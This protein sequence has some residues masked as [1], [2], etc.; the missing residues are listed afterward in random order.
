MSFKRNRKPLSKR[1]RTLVQ[2]ANW[3]VFA[4]CATSAAS[5][6]AVCA[7]MIPYPQLVE[8]SGTDMADVFTLTAVLAVLTLISIVALWLL[9]Y[10]HALQWLGQAVLVSAIGGS[11]GWAWLFIY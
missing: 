11:L 8:E 5:W 4:I 7:M 2:I 3:G 10:R 6:L 9:H 1:L